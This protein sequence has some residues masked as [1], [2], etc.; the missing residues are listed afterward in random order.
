[1]CGRVAQSLLSA[2]SLLQVCGVREACCVFLAGALSPDN[3][4]GIR[5]FAELHACTDLT[6]CAQRFVETHFVEV[7][8]AP[9]AHPPTA[10]L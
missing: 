3:A 6:L 9:S 5:A 4:L 10:P 1:M 2:A 7:T 8:L